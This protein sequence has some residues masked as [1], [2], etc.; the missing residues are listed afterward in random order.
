MAKIMSILPRLIVN[1]ITEARGVDNGE[2]DAGSL[3]IE[4]YS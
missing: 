4:L 3:L 2:G 1:L